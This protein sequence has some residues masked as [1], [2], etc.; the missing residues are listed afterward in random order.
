MK[1]SIADCMA[2]MVIQLKGKE[3]WEAILETAGLPKTTTFLASQDI[4]DAAV[5]KVVGAACKVLGKTLPEIADAFGLYWVRYYA[6]KIYSSYYQ[7]MSA[8]EF[9]LRM[10]TVHEKVTKTLANAH[11]PRFTYEEPESNTLI[12]NYQSNRGLIDFLVG[13]IKGVGTHFNQPL[14]VTKLSATKVKVVFKT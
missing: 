5:L 1:G 13:L 11:P 9:L 12:M 10:D 6:P 2:K 4:D 3:Q 7:V 14:T 8:K